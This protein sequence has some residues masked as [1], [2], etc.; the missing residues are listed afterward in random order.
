M[1]PKIVSFIGAFAFL[2]SST[3]CVLEKSMGYILQHMQLV[4]VKN[5]RFDIRHLIG[6]AIPINRPHVP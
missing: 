6:L 3:Q 4:S 1:G 2:Q 5:T